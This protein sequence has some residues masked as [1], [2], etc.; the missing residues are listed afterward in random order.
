MNYY[1]IL[2]LFT[3]LLLF[4]WVSVWLCIF[5]KCVTLSVFLFDLRVQFFLIYFFCFSQ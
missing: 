4:E 3:L 1:P 2:I 5:Y